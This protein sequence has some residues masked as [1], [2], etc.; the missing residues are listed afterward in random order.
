MRDEGKSAAEGA[1]RNVSFSLPLYIAKSG[2]MPGIPP[3]SQ[4]ATQPE[5]DVNIQRTEQGGGKNLAVY[6]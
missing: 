4:L 1:L 6:R 5:D 3:A 2:S